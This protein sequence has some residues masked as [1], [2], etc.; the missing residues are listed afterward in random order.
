MN[1][2]VNKAFKSSVGMNNLGF[3][4][5]EKIVITVSKAKDGV[6]EWGGGWSL[7][8]TGLRLQMSKLVKG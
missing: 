3:Y 2:D 5:R 7:S 1:T 4:T 6:R 8:Y